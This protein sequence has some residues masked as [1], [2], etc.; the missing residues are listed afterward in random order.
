M[1]IRCALLVPLPPNRTPSYNVQTQD[2]RAIETGRPVT[3]KIKKRTVQLPQQGV[4]FVEPSSAG[5]LSEML[6]PALMDAWPPSPLSRA[7]L[8]TMR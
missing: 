5:L 6:V 4:F 2:A 1:T 7:L 3:W 8:D